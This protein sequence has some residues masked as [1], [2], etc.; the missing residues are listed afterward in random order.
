LGVRFIDF[1]KFICICNYDN[2][3]KTTSAVAAAAAAAD[4]KK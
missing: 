3:K 4:T 2:N 1:V